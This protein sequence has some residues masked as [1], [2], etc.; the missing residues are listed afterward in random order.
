MRKLE[1]LIAIC[2]VIGLSAVRA[3]EPTEDVVVNVPDAALQDAIAKVLTRLKVDTAEIT[4]SELAKIR[5]LECKDQDLKSLDGIEHCTNLTEANFSGNGI[6]D[7]APLAS[8]VKLLTLDVSKNEITNVS[9]L[10]SLKQLRS[11]KLDHNLVVDLSP[12]GSAKQLTMLHASHNKL[13]KIPKLGGLKLL[14]AAYLAN[15]EIVDINAVEGLVSLESLDLTGNKVN[16]VSP[17]ST[18]QHLRWTFLTDN[19]IT[20]LT[21]LAKMVTQSGAAAR[22]NAMFWRLYLAGNS[23]DEKSLSAITTLRNAGMTVVGP[24]KEP[25]ESV[26]KTSPD[27]AVPKE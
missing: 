1:I 27:A 13:T 22:S 25:R 15:N 18:L 8:C 3:D 19:N 26:N 20:D 24:E 4:A 14:H 11:L 21:P 7:L 9:P 23:V 17:L 6:T 16:N 5:Y 2:L 10:A 12:I